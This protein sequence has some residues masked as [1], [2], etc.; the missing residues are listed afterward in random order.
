[1]RSRFASGGFTL[2][3][4]LVV[5]SIIA[6]LAMMIFAG[7]SKARAKASSAKCANHLRIWMSALQT[8]LDNNGGKFPKPLI[9]HQFTALMGLNWRQGNPNNSPFP[10]SCPA[11]RWPG[12]HA[13]GTPWHA[14][15]GYSANSCLIPPSIISMGNLHHNPPGNRPGWEDDEYVYTGRI[16]RPTEILVF[17]DAGQMTHGGSAAM[18]QW[19]GEFNEMWHHRHVHAS[20]ADEPVST[21]PESGIG[22]LWWYPEG[23]T[24]MNPRHD[25]IAMAVFLDGHVEGVPWGTLLNRNLHTLY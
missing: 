5:T 7:V 1:M 14:A 22:Q 13:N 23:E 17:S 10:Y 4:L 12:T 11:A 9:M 16:T 21:A 15:S 18:C 8:H 6:I 20:R 3:E 19:W 24:L 25:G 2:V